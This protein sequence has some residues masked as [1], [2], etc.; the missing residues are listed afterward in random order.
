VRKEHLVTLVAEERNAA[1]HLP[2]LPEM[3]ADENKSIRRKKQ[4]EGQY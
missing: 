1:P 3:D 4:D 2:A